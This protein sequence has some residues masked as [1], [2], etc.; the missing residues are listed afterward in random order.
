MADL[1]PNKDTA[2]CMKSVFKPS[3]IL[4]LYYHVGFLQIRSHTFVSV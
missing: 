1:L 3:F 2:S 4:G